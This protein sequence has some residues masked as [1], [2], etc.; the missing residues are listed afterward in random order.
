[1]APGGFFAGLEPATSGVT[2][3]QF[4]RESGYQTKSAAHRV[5]YQADS[6]GD[7]SGFAFPVN[8]SSVPYSRRT[9]ALIVLNSPLCVAPDR[10]TRR[11]PTPRRRRILR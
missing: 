3:L 5:D 8:W 2:G 11:T 7:V 10:L 9:I 4:C 6:L 1:M